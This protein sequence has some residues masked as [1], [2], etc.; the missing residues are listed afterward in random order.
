M[1]RRT[2]PAVAWIAGALAGTLVVAA[3]P[4]DL[5]LEWLGAGSASDEGPPVHGRPGEEVRLDYRL[6]N[7]GARPAAAVELTTHTTLGPAG[8]PVE[9][10]PGPDSG[11]EYRR[12]VELELTIGLR[13]V[14][15][16]ARLRSDADD[17]TR[18]PTPDDN[19]IC[20]EVEVAR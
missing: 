1:L 18:D 11:E 4:P 8:A 7:V 15:I 5:R 19:R 13:E 20:R 14:C 12:S 6:M 9:L 10:R 17:E 2:L 16:E 3:A